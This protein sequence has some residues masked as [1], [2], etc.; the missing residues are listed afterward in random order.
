M[1][2]RELSERIELTDE[3]DILCSNYTL[4]EEQPPPD[5]NLEDAFKTGC[6][7][8]IEDDSDE[9]DGPPEQ[10]PSVLNIKTSHQVFNMKQSNSDTYKGSV[11]RSFNANGTMTSGQ[12]NLGNT[13]DSMKGALNSSRNPNIILYKV[14]PSTFD[15]IGSVDDIGE[16]ITIQ[17]SPGNKNR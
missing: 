17:S 8:I 11:T 5:N 1:N 10:L 7:D 15:Q 9:E 4:T 12:V 6:A 14:D 16:T 3:A 2:N 13:I